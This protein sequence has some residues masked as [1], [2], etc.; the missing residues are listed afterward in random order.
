MRFSRLVNRACLVLAVV[1]AG[2]CG[3]REVTVGQ[4]YPIAEPDTL[5]EIQTRAQQVDWI[6][7]MRKQPKDYSAFDSVRLPRNA[8][9][10][11]R[12]FD[13]TYVLPAD[14]TDEQ[15]KVLA[16]KG[17]KVNPLT[18]MKLPGRYIVISPTSADYAWLDSVAKPESEDLI[19]IA[20]GNVLTE[21]ET[22]H[23]KL[24]SL[25]ERFIERFGLAGVPSIVYQEGALLRVDEHV[26][27]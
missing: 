1:A 6:R 25:D 27:K 9:A 24:Y 12:L 26:A 21:I 5:Q 4:T 2:V 11:S 14:V 17:T 22:T 10:G 13:P 15:G 20:N 8:K 16:P 7:W 18:R 23:R 19:L 3:A